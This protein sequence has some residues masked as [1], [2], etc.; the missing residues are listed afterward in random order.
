[1][2]SLDLS[3]G[4]DRALG[5]APVV[6][7]AESPRLGRARVQMVLYQQQ[8]LW[9]FGGWSAV[10]VTNNKKLL[11]IKKE[12]WNRL[13]AGGRGGGG[14]R[15]KEEFNMQGSAPDVTKQHEA[16][17]YDLPAGIR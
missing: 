6:A 1:M 10:Q 5:K 11:E 4:C 2:F 7:L 3:L 16:Q 14:Q 15:G 13:G 12:E 9:A 8:Q 17:V